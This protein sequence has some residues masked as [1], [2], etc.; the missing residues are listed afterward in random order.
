LNER[1]ISDIFINTTISY[2]EY[3]LS[4][5]KLMLATVFAC[6]DCGA[7]LEIPEDALPGE[8]IGCPDCGLDYVIEVDE[9]GGKQLKE[10]L[11]EGEDWGE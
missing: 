8:I 7:E 10:L 1:I 3:T 9:S 4:S 2:S 11:I 6:T 5:V